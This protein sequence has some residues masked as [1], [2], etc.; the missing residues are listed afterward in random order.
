MP[1]FLLEKLAFR[2][3]DGLIP[4]MPSTPPPL[5]WI[6]RC[7]VFAAPGYFPPL[8]KPLLGPSSRSQ[9]PQGTSS[10]PSR[11]H[12]KVPAQGP[13]S[14][15]PSSSSHFKV[16]LKGPSSGSRFQAPLQGSSSRSH[17][18][19][20]QLKFPLQGPTSRSQFEGAAQDAKI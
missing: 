9:I 8:R 13:T 11:S 17:F 6:F 14:T 18:N 16:P 20:S 2:Q 7:R 19:R 10:G 12:F 5:L 3:P 4:A 15:G 1:W